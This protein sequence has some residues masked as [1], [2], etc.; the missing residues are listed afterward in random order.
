MSYIYDLVKGQEE[1]LKLL[2][3][4]G[5]S[6]SSIPG[7][8]K[9]S[10][11]VCEA[12]TIY[13]LIKDKQYESILDV[14]TG[15]GFSCLYMAKALTDSGVSGKVTTIDI[16]TEFTE[17]ARS[18]IRKFGLE[19]YVEFISGDSTDVL[20]AMPPASF[21]LTIIDGQHKYDQCKKDFTQA[22]RLVS[23]GGCIV[24]D[25][26]YLRPEHN[27][28]PRNVFQEI[29]ESKGELYYFEEKIFDIFQYMEDMSEI[30]RMKEKWNLRHGSFVLKESNPKEVMG[31]FFKK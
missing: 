11:K 19:E 10:I 30:S 5:Y 29:D 21:D 25:D 27:P 12:Q 22:D 13:S 2:Y 8:V 31:F 9:G 20:G 6:V 28:G 14:G 15:P 26:I 18:L 1:S 23:P 4:Q 17:R 16:K 3:S 24:F 7:Y